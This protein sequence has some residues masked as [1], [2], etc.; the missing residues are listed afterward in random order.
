M[1]HRLVVVTVSTVDG[2]VLDRFGLAHCRTTQLSA[3][4]LRAC[5]ND[6]ESVGSQTSATFLLERIGQYVSFPPAPWPL[7]EEGNS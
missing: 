3:D 2:A 1:E 4:D 5:D 6:T 7:C